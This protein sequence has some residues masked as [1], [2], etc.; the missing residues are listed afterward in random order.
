MVKPIV[1]QSEFLHY[2]DRLRRSKNKT[3]RDSILLGFN[4]VEEYP[5]LLHKKLLNQH[6]L[7]T[8]CLLYTSDAADE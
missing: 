6:A 1:S 4:P 2:A 7:I 8:G 5:V 3:E